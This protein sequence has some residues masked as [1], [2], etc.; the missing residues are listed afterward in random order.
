MPDPVDVVEALLFASDA[1]LE[2]ERIRDVLDLG[3]VA[4]ARALVDELR[5]RYEDAN[6]ALTITEVGGG[7]RMVTRAELA[8]WLVRL[9][10]ARTRVRLSRAALEALAIVAYKQPVSRPEV[11]AIRGVNSEGVLESLMERRLVRIAGRKEAPGRPFLYETTR[12]FLIAFGLRDLNDLP[13]VEGELI[14]PDLAGDAAGATASGEATGESVEHA[15][16]ETEQ[17]SRPSGADVTT[18]S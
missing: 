9:A 8:P 7:Y 12:E 15:Q 11:D 2:P 16:A 18:G 1:P 17:D 5:V 14:I 4:E 6:R 3:G 10:R 13:K